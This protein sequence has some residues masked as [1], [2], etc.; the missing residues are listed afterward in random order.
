MPSR[1]R[2][3]LLPMRWTGVSGLEGVA[4]EA[5]A[6]AYD[7]CTFIE[8]VHFLGANH[9]L[10]EGVRRLSVS[11]LDR[12]ILDTRGTEALGTGCHYRHRQTQHLKR[13]CV[14]RVSILWSVYM[15]AAHQS[16]FM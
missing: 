15:S 8:Q 3:D 4:S 9:C 2:C 11:S 6:H 13:L 1:A 10:R 12:T 16:L 5:H 7:P 14:Q